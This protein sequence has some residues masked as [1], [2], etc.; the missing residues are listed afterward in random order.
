MTAG[1]DLDQPVLGQDR[2]RGPRGVP[3]DAVLL[4]QRGDRRHARAGWQVPGLDPGA[5]LAGHLAV[6]RH[7]RTMIN[8]HLCSVEDHG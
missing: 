6:G 7:R 8:R 2:Q 4:H 5:Q 3:G 1:R